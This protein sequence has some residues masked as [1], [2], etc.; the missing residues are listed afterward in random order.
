MAGP[1]KP[2]VVRRWIESLEAQFKAK[3]AALRKQLRTWPSLTALLLL[4]LWVLTLP[5]GFLLTPAGTAAPVALPTQMN[6][7]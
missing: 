6:C 1:G 7:A 2:D 5:I 3:D 4:V